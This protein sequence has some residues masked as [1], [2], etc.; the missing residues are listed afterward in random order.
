FLLSIQHVSGAAASSNFP[1]LTVSDCVC[2]ACARVCAI[3]Y[4]HVIFCVCECVCVCARVLLCVCV[5]VYVCVCV[6]VCVCAFKKRRD[7]VC[8]CVL[9]DL[10]EVCVCV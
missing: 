6:C 8:V 5:C 10:Y 9:T 4:A 1:E 2:V 3:L 7:G